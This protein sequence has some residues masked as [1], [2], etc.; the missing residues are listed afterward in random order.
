[1]RLEEVIKSSI[2]NVFES[3]R[4]G[5]KEAE[6]VMRR[7]DDFRIGIE[8]EYHPDDY[9]GEDSG[10]LTDHPDF[11]DYVSQQ[12]QEQTDE[13]KEYFIQDYDLDSR[14]GSIFEVSTNFTYEQLEYVY[15]N[16]YRPIDNG[17]FQTLLDGDPSDFQQALEHIE[18]FVNTFKNVFEYFLSQEFEDDYMSILRYAEG[19]DLDED[20]FLDNVCPAILEIKSS[21]NREAIENLS[22]YM[23]NEFIPF[24]NSINLFSR[25]QLLDFAYSE[26]RQ[27]LNT[28][29]EYMI[30]FYDEFDDAAR[31]LGNTEIDYDTIKSHMEVEVDVD[32]DQA[33]MAMERDGLTMG[34]T[35][36][37]INNEVNG[38]MGPR[39]IEAVK[40]EHDN[41]VEVITVPMSLDNTLE[42]MED[43]FDHISSDGSTSD[44]SGMHVN[45]SIDSDKA[46]TPD[47]VDPL[48]LYLLMDQSFIG[49]QFDPRTHVKH[50]VDNLR[51]Y[52]II[53]AAK[54]YDRGGFYELVQYTR[55]LLPTD[56]KY[57][58][59][60]MIGVSF[61]SSSRVEFR[62]FG[63]EDYHENF[64]HAKW[65][66]LR[67]C[68]MLLSA[69][70]DDFKYEQ[71]AKDL[72]RLWDRAAK[73]DLNIGFADVV[74]DVRS[75]G[76][77]EPT[78]FVHMIGQIIDV[79]APS[80]G[81]VTY[82]GSLNPINGQFITT[83]EGFVGYFRELEL[84]EVVD[85]MMR[86]AEITGE[87]HQS[88]PTEIFQQIV[89]QLHNTLRRF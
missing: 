49:T 10:D 32:I 77:I 11:D 7:S 79:Y 36:D 61:S 45:M 37:D 13:Q 38:I 57:V 43:M 16:L 71:Y 54:A 17:D 64:E 40:E 3:V 47:T 18:F 29:F 66:L 9:S 1:M 56:D 78:E 28:F 65:N 27:E 44:N 30:S 25:D 73:D 15:D 35:L 81:S 80:R 14:L 84:F 23:I 89:Q 31:Q 24:A 50:F 88:P 85:L 52:H 74:D 70:D 76:Q 12:Y 33:I 48:K 51:E 20:Y 26:A 72:F 6:E 68:H 63:G 60:N 55:S 58:A 4:F 8:Y 86:H 5:H 42:F 53:D 46:F 83:N 22:K 82:V 19:E 39:A 75:D 67:T 34:R 2:K 59:I 69:F 21:G 41:Q 87:I 62:L